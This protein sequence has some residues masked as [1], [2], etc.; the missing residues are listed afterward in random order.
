[1]TGTRNRKTLLKTA[2]VLLATLIFSQTSNAHLPIFGNDDEKPSLA[3]LLDDVKD[4]VVNIS[5]SLRD[6]RVTWVSDYW[7]GRRPYRIQRDVQ[8]AGSGVVIDAAKG[9]VITN[10][11]VIDG[12]HKVVITLQDRRSFDAQVL[13]SDDQTDIALLQIEAEG[14]TELALADSDRLRVG[15]FVIAIGNP[16]GLGQSVTSG[17]VSAL[18]R[19]Q[20]NLLAAEDFIQTDASINPGNSGGAL[21][22]LD[23]NL[24]GINSAIT[25]PQTSAG[26]GFAVPANIVRVITDQLVEFGDIRRGSFGLM[27]A[28]LTKQLA[29]LLDITT[30]DGVVVTEVIPGSG[31]DQADMRIDDVIVELDGKPISNNADLITSI[32]L[33]RIGQ[34]FDLVVIRGGE[35]V[36]VE[37]VVQ[38]YERDDE[39]IPGVYV[40]NIPSSHPY[41]GRIAGIIVSTVDNRE[42][43]SRLMDGDIILQ[44]NR[45]SIRNVSELKNFNL[46]SR[47]LAFRVLRGTT[48]FR[49]LVN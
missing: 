6:D 42:N 28:P 26:I 49:L 27:I 18:G 13:G 2:F 34:K 45:Y 37:G 5:V 14:L 3:S 47:P 4:A 20:L 10:H 44:I 21:I 9:Y 1:M 24:V 43:Q 40:D 41:Y 32:A 33:L 35:R 36:P 8:T 29:E 25:N 46:A 38:E 7:L 19:N 12:A 22:D 39:L 15:D 31:A 11:H 48:E 16:L 30:T 17:I 23:G